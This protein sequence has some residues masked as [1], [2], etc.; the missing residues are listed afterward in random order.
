MTSKNNRVLGLIVND[1]SILEFHSKNHP[2][3]KR[4][5]LPTAEQFANGRSTIKAVWQRSENVVHITASNMEAL[6]RA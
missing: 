3:V 5:E 6:V 4:S 2:V 1:L